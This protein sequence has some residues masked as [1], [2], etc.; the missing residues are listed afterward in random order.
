[1]A[2]HEGLKRRFPEKNILE[3]SSK[4]LTPLGIKLSAFNLKKYVPSIGK[5]VPV[6]CIY[7]G[8][9]VFA[10]GGPYIDLYLGTSRAAKGDG[11][12][13]T[14]GALRGFSFEGKDYPLVPTTAFY[15]WLYIS[16]LMENKELADELMKYDSFTDIEFSPEKSK[17]CQAR[18]A[19]LFVAL[20]SKGLLEFVKD[21]E[22][23]VKIAY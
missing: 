11:R 4:S 15:D 5:Y 17:N 19:A 6:E 1:M 20:H 8:S 14:S 9:K 22:Q 23:F 3:I 2:I 7:Q 21:F 12:L 13:K 18:A 10:V 16:A